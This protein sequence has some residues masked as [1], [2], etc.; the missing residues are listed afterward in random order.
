MTK[1]KEYWYILHI[2]TG[3]IVKYNNKSETWGYVD[4]GYS[5]SKDYGTIVSL[6]MCSIGLPNMYNS[7]F[8]I[9][10]SYYK[11]LIDKK[12]DAAE[13]HFKTK[14]DA[15]D[16]LRDYVLSARVKQAARRDLRYVGLSTA[17]P[18]DAEFIILSSNDAT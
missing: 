12:K 4:D 14:T 9:P 15:R 1:K 5:Y 2:P 3:N 7:N 16:F 8:R 17:Y 18:K 6:D 10:P 11:T 13:M